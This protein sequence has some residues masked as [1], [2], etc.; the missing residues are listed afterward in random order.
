MVELLAS[1]L[2]LVV[3]GGRRR[4]VGDGCRADSDVGGGK[5]GAGCL[6]HLGGG[7]H[8]HAVD[9]CGGRLVAGA[10]HERDLGS[11]C[12]RGFRE[13]KAHLAGRPVADEAHGVNRL[14][15]GASG[16]DDAFTSKRSVGK[17][18]G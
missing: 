6:V 1:L 16:D 7:N 10:G 14:V 12:R 9:A 8:V 3:R 2:E 11:G 15:R 13:R 17:H 4:V 5:G 18:A